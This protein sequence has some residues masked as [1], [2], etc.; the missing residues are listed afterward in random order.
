MGRKNLIKFRTIKLII[1]EHI[2]HFTVEVSLPTTCRESGNCYSVL[3]H[4]ISDEGST[5]KY[6]GHKD[7][8]HSIV[9][10]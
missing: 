9:Y 6:G 7:Y 8:A 4:V 1:S 10:I 5:E 3:V 2:L